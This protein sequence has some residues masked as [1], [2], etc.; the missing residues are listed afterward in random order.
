[1]TGGAVTGGGVLPL[2]GV[3]VVSLEQAVA[4]PFATR[5]L[6]DLGARVVKVERVDGGDFARGYDDAVHGLSSHFVWLNRSKESIAVDVKSPPGRAVLHA[7][8]ARAD[9]LVQNLAPG[10]SARLGLAAAEVRARHPGL[11]VAD[12]SGYGSA[13][14][15]RDRRAYDMLVQA[16]A[17]LVSVTGTAAHPVKTGV[18]TAD[19]AAGL[20]ASHAI[21]AA[22]VRRGRTGE[23]CGIE[24]SMFDALVEWMGHPLLTSMYGGRSVG[25]HG[26]AHPAIVPYDGYPTRDG[27]VLVGVQ[28]DRQWQRLTVALDRPGLGADA[29]LSTNRDRVAARERVDAAVAEATATFSTAT[30]LERLAAAGVPAARVTEV[31]DLADHPQLRDRDRWAD[32]Q[33]ERGPVEAVR[34]PAVLAGVEVRMGPVPAL[35]EHTDRLLAEL[36]HPPEEVAALRA[37]GVVA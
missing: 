32:V 2:E 4:A 7:L 10:A 16:E 29:A 3:T 23:G 21:L 19:L 11:V 17:G 25:R 15:D 26:L 8:V 30:L 1:M 14:P 5:T 35:G 33:T 18:P 31:G 36:G 28:N 6:A 27:R 24:V 37:A 34:P 9:V 13:G 22:L 20:H 12:I